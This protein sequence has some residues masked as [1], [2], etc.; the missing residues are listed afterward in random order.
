MKQ[1]EYEGPK[2]ARTEEVGEIIKLANRVFRQEAGDM[3]SE[4]P[5][6]FDSARPERMLIFTK[7]GLP[8][9]LVG[10]CVDDV[11]LLGCPL[12]VACV[13]AVCTLESERGK[14][15]AGRLMDEAAE[16]ARRQGASVMLISGRRSLYQ[17]RGAAQVGV[18]RRYHVSTRQLPHES[19]ITTDEVNADN[20]GKALCFFETEPIRFC[21]T[22]ED[23]AAQINCKWGMNRP[24]KTHLVS[25][26]GRASAVV[27]V[28]NLPGP[29]CRTGEPPRVCEMAGPRRDVLAALR[30]IAEPVEAETVTIDGYCWDDAL[31][32]ACEAASANVET[33]SHSGITKLLDPTRLWNSFAPLL[34]AR[35][36]A[37]NFSEIHLSAEAD[38]LR[39]HT[40][41]FEMGDQKLI[42]SGYEEL[43]KAIFGSPQS[44]PL[45][46]RSGELA[47]IL[48]QALPLPLPLYGL[49]YA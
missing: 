36:G 10:V 48:T 2:P 45:A 43:T 39:I 42:L 16:R 14:G 33:V 24:C 1:H 32:R 3:G 22:G 34:S 6:L 47:K 44:N 9:S 18:F 31:R 28:S 37:K 46:D 15:L 5:L 23:Y 25:R 7:N 4:Y 30:Q 35:I 26:G 17:R 19:D 27:S 29:R 21:R 49:N 20:C 8:V 41:T 11:S 40:L 13:G 38:D 12:K